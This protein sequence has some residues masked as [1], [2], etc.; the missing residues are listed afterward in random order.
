MLTSNQINEGFKDF[1]HCS[2]QVLMEWAEELGYERDEAA[3]MAAPFGGGLTQG[4]TCGAVC[5]AMIAIGM[6]YGHCKPGDK[7]GN[8]TLNAKAAEFYKEFKAKNGSTICRELVGYDFSKEG[9]LEKAMASGKIFEVC[10][11]LVQSSLEILDK[12]M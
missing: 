3:R 5:A 6:R 2:M 10:P 1:M 11:R 8:D 4:D 9:E 12:I 7:E